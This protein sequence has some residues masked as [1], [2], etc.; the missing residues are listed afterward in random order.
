[1]TSGFGPAFG[2]KSMTECICRFQPLARNAV[3]HSFDA[4]QEAGVL[5]TDDAPNSGDGI[6]K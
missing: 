6:H 3:R 4:N 1:M 2:D 5:H